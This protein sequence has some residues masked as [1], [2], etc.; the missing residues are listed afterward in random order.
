MP[1]DR[2]GRII[3]RAKAV[4]GSIHFQL[5]CHPRP[6][7]G[8]EIPKVDVYNDCAYFE[9]PKMVFRVRT[10]V[11]LTEKMGEAS[12]VPFLSLKL[13]MA[14]S[15][16]VSACSL[17]SAVDLEDATVKKSPAVFSPFQWPRRI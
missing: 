10:P 12:T 13:S 11:A 16:N 17:A 7:Y 6:D 5:S 8:R 14:I 15:S 9:T 1:V 4:Q 2:S 3:R